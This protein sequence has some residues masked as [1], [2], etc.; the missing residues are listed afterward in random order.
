MGGGDDER[1]GGEAGGGGAGV[2]AAVGH[3]GARGG[4]AAVDVG[5]CSG[6]VGLREFVDRLVVGLKELHKTSLML[7]SVSSLDSTSAEISELKVQKGEGGGYVGALNQS[8][9][10]RRQASVPTLASES[11]PSKF[12]EILLDTQ[13]NN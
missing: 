6:C 2:E 13:K 12:L 10:E 5:G 11:T 9:R 3:G 7:R 1:G 4:G 8:N